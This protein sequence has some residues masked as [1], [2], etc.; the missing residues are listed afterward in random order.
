M[1]RLSTEHKVQTPQA[2][3]LV[4]RRGPTKSIHGTGSTVAQPGPLRTV[5][6]SKKFLLIFRWSKN[7]EFA[8]MRNSI[9]LG[10]DLVSDLSHASVA[11]LS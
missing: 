8:P 9:A 7:S 5:G 4:E 10:H 3:L 2:Q 6:S 1:Q 11:G